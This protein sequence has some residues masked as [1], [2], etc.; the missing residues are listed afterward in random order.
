MFRKKF[1]DE[2]FKENKPQEVIIDNPDTFITE[3]YD[4]VLSKVLDEGYV[5]IDKKI[6][7]VDKYSYTLKRGING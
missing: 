5:C 2:S 4:I 6:I 3:D 7:G 1:F